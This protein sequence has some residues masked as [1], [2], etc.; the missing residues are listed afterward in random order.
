MKVLHS[1]CQQV[2]KTEQWPQDW[3]R[4]DFISTPKKGNAKKCSNYHTIAL[5]SY[6]SIVML[7][8][9]QA[10]WT[11]YEFNSRWTEN[12]QMFKLDLE[13]AEEWE[14]KLP[15]S[16]GSLKI[17]GVWEKHLLLLPWLYQ[18]LW[19]CGS[20]QTVGNSSRDGN[21]R[22]PYLAPEK[23]VCRSRSNS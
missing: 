10:V 11:L 14:I 17:K 2:W 12:F 16:V 5:I 21:T 13:K 7:T 23:P 3:K 4:S 18:R 15:I 20:E 1:I 6:A 9:L 22:L 19:L 8:I